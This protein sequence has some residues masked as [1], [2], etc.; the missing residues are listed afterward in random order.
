MELTRN[1]PE[2][3]NQDILSLPFILI[4]AP[5]ECR[6]NCEML[7]DRTNYAF[8]FDMPFTIN[9]DIEVLKLL[10]SSGISAQDLSEFPADISAYVSEYISEGIFILI[11]RRSSISLQFAFHRQHLQLASNVQGSHRKIY[12]ELGCHE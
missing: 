6:I 4:C 1:N 10:S 3:L 12:D 5:K 7:E 2:P 11:N 8:D 9:E